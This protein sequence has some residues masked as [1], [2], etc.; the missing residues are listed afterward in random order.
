MVNN[1]QSKCAGA[2]PGSR[3]LFQNRSTAF[4]HRG[5]DT[6]LMER[7]TDELR[8]AGFCVTVDC[9]GSE[10]PSK[11]D[12]VHLFNAALPEM[13]RTYAERAKQAGVPFVVTTL[14]ENIR[15]F[16]NQS[17]SL[18]S[19]LIGYVQQAQSRSWW[20]EHRP[21]LATIPVC[22]NFPNDWTFRNAAA[23]LT[24]GVSES[25]VL[26]ADYPGIANIVELPMG[27]EVG[28]QGEAAL[29]ER[30]YGV[31]DFVLCVGRIES[32]KNQLMLLKALE[33]SEL[34]VVLVGGGF[35]YQPEYD[36]AVRAFK[37]RGR[38][39]I[40]DRLSPQMLAS[41][42]AACRVHVLASW[43]EL[44]GLVTLEA[45]ACG[46]NVV[47]TE[48]GSGVDYI[49]DHGW[50][51]DP[52]SEHSI[53]T[54]IGAAFYGPV[55]AEL[56][57]R[58][59]TFSWTAAGKALVQCYEG[60][61][62]A[63]TSGAIQVP[64]VV[65]S[66][67]FS[68]QGEGWQAALERGESAA[69]AGEALQAEQILSKVWRE[70]PSSGRAA[71]AIAALHFSQ[72]RS[73]EAKSWFEKAISL[74]PEDARGHVG[75]GMCFMAEGAWETASKQFADALHIDPEQ[76]VG[77]RNLVECS[78]HLQKFDVLERALRAYLTR[79][80]DDVEMQFCLAGCCFKQGNVTEAKRLCREILAR[81]PHHQGARDLDEH[82]LRLP[83]VAA[84]V[85]Q[86]LQDF[87]RSDERIALLEDAK[88]AR[89]YSE[90]HSGCVQ[91]LAEV[92]V[93][94]TSWERAM[95]LHGD[96]Y[97]LEGDLEE[98]SRCYQQVLSRNPNSPFGLCGKGV[99][100]ANSNRWDDARRCFECALEVHPRY[101][102]AMAGIALCAG[103]S[104]DQKGAWEWNI[105][106]LEA[107]PENTRALLGV[108]EY[109]YPL[110]KLKEVQSALERYLE[111][112]PADLDFVYALA[113]CYFAQE[114]L[115]EAKSEISKIMLFAPEHDSA[116][117]LKGLIAEVEGQRGR[118]AM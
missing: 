89:R 26:R 77:L 40:L 39:L 107:N 15:S 19:A 32:R 113:G 5:G 18:A 62:P 102:V 36:R 112:H 110:Q 3:I 1:D 101:D 27:Y 82:I 111:M 109:G 99:L 117:E 61:L 105:R 72:Q 115:Q 41:A 70:N 93:G 67:D 14:Y 98:A 68:D 100:E 7:Y 11:Y 85:S 118:A 37:R 6:V 46:K 25:T 114:K 43:Y 56:A 96:A 12:L 30:E 35:S 38:T 63:Q 34:P 79:R 95:V 58:A 22:S 51:C 87:G 78:F 74:Q 48:C 29:F 94:S 64:T 21:N 66:Y 52:A 54:A 84:P 83:V 60:I 86:P 116:K 106:A 44:P 33:E 104:G 9:Q 2:R 31:K 23:L 50:Y 16:H 55:P 57:M 42:Y 24:T 28:A 20:K 8:R 108:I 17:V 97:A 75:L 73:A 90:V 69:R 4:T 81:S 13:L 80:A 88:R 59:R 49:G 92:A 53:R 71:R 103:R 65:G 47:L 45:A 10:D 91:V 76:L